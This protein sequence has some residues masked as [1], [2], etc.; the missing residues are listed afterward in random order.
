MIGLTSKF[1]KVD[2]TRLE[3]RE[4]PAPPR[5]DL[6]PT[7]RPN[8]STTTIEVPPPELPGIETDPPD[9]LRPAIHDPVPPE[10]P[11]LAP[12]AIVSRVQGGPGIGFPSTDDFYPSAAI[13][14][15]EKGSATV[16]VCV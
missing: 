15:G 3:T 10:S 5:R 9:A 8:V 12:P 2:A 16:G 4:I 7:P 13:F 1:I 6:P 14:M 11:P